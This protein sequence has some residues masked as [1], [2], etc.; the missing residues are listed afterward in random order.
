[1]EEYPLGGGIAEALGFCGPWVRIEYLVIPFIVAVHGYAITGGFQLSYCWD[2]VV[3]AENT[4]F[5]DTHAKF[6]WC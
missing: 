1:L 3:A 2:M 4:K 6:A 5:G